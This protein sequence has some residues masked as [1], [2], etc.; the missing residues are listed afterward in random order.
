MAQHMEKGMRGQLVVGKGSGD[1]W[2]VPGISDDYYRFSYLGERS[3]YIAVFLALAGF[4]TT[5]WLTRRSK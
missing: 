3:M 1:L 2:S 4:L 5:F